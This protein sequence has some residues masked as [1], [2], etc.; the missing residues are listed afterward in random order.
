VSTVVVPYGI[1]FNKWANQQSFLRPELNWPVASETEENWQEWANLVYFN[2]SNQYPFI[3]YPSRKIYPHNE[4]W[5][6]WASETIY[7]LLSI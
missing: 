1:S 4:D 7:Q 6:R 5:R 2:S 3:P